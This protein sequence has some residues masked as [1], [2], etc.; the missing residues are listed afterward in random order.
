MKRNEKSDKIM[1]IL[2]WHEILAKRDFRRMREMSYDNNG[3]FN[4]KEDLDLGKETISTAQVEEPSAEQK[5]S[6]ESAPSNSSSQEKAK[7]GNS[8]DFIPTE[9]KVWHYCL[10]DLTDEFFWAFIFVLVWFGIG[11]KAPQSSGWLTAYWVL[12][13][14]FAIGVF[15]FSVFI[16]TPLSIFFR[17]KNGE[18]DPNAKPLLY[19]FISFVVFVT[20]VLV[21]V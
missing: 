19:D 3:D 10:R 17:R 8:P 13:V 11:P 1:I 9:T 14:L 20:A 21:L 18:E 7:S 12:T 5:P 2:I 16:Y 6:E 15:Y 4:F